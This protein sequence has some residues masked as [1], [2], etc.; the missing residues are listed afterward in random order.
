M[1]SSGP[2]RERTRESTRP[3]DGRRAG[4]GNPA[5]GFENIAASNSR[6]GSRAIWKNG[7]H[8]HI[9]IAFAERQARLAGAG[10]LQFLLVLV[11]FARGEVAGLRIER[12]NQPVKGHGGY[13]AHVRFIDVVFLRF[14]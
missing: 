13:G 12:F 4:G 3:R 14:M 10:V 8:D 1:A 5:N 11:V 7:E 9:A 6:F 2:A